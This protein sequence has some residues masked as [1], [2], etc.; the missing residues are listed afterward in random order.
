MKIFHQEY[1][2]FSPYGVFVVDSEGNYIEANKAAEKITGYSAKELIAMRLLDIIA[3]HDHQKALDHFNRVLKNGRASGTVSFIRKDRTQRY[4]NVEAVKISPDRFLGFVND[5]TEQKLAE[6]ALKESESQKNLILNSMTEMMAYYDTD[7]RIIWSNRASATS[8]GKT[9]EELKGKHCYEIWHQRKQ[10]CDGCPLIKAKKTKSPQQ[11]EISTPDG[12]TWFLRGYPILD[13]NQNVT[14]LVEFGQDITLRRKA[15]NERKKL[16]KTLKSKNAELQAII[17][18]ASHDLRTPL[19]NITGFSQEL[20]SDIETL[21]KIIQ[22]AQLSD[23]NKIQ[24][25]NILNQSIPEAV[26]YISTSAAKTQQLINS[27]LKVSRIGTKQIKIEQLD[28]NNIVSEIIETL[29]YKSKELN[30]QI[31]AENLPQC[32]ADY[33]LMNQIFSN[34]IGNA[35]KYLK[36][37]K[38]G[39]IKIAGKKTNAKAS[40]CI[41]DNGIGIEP[42]QTEKI[43]NIFHRVRNQYSVDGEGVGLAIVKRALDRLNGQISVQSEPDKGT[44]FCFSLPAV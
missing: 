4:W 9:A 24:T 12:R 19:A 23:E 39:S 43:F 27:L 8:V 13:K 5:I 22:N 18:F 29:Q 33:Y 28:V 31:T 16:V 1:I 38:P 15:E 7:F 2:N 25:Q 10:P 3:P 21:K 30:A 44:K 36:P 26:H 14:A 34:L 40:Y 17:Y 41:E 32:K 42:N 20:S 35:V 6:K 37:D 11:S